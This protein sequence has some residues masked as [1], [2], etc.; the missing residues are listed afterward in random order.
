MPLE[1]GLDSARNRR[2]SPQGNQQDTGI[3]RE[4][5]SVSILSLAPPALNSD[6][7][8]VSIEKDLSVGD[9]GGGSATSVYNL[10][11]T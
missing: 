7:E 2:Y 1:Y 8:A 5:G 4:R 6:A 3:H 11:K 9:W 10:T